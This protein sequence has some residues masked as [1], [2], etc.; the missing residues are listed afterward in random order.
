MDIMKNI[1]NRCDMVFLF[2]HSINS[3]HHPEPTL[4]GK[5]CQF[6]QDLDWNEDNKADHGVEPLPSAL[7]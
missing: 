7:R 6:W 5:A 3:S 4:L 2:N 1:M